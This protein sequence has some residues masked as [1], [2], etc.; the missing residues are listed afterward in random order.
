VPT[1]T[2][3]VLYVFVVLHHARRRIVHFNVTA[4]PTAEWVVRQLRDAFPFDSAPR[5]LIHDNDSIFGEAVARCL[6]GMGI[7]QVLTLLGSPWQNAY[8]ERVIG[9][10]RR[11]CL[12]HVIAL[13]ESHLIRV[14]DEFLAYYHASRCHQSL[15][16]DSP[17]GRKP[18]PA[19]DRPIISEA[20][21]GGLHHRYRRAA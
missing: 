1:I 11:E 8:A 10:M 12:D 19:G 13:S 7:T 18:E 20:L 4:H 16:R 2:G 3:R 6:R 15:G 14:V 5:F 9:T 21:V 17:C